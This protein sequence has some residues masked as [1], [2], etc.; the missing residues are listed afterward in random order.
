MGG[1]GTHTDS[2]SGESG[3][4]LEGRS[5]SCD[6]LE[7]RSCCENTP[8]HSRAASTRDE[9]PSCTNRHDPFSLWLGAQNWQSK[10]L[11]SASSETS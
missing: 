9:G 10:A 4:R 7:G 3:D 6:R 2:E 1:R 5:E 11:A 8:A